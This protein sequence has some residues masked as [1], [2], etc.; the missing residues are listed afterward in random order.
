MSS[1]SKSDL[2]AGA[3]AA[4]LLAGLRGPA[5]HRAFAEGVKGGHDD[6]AHAGAVGDQQR[7]RGNA[8]HNAQHGEEAAQLVA[9]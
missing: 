9:L 1:F 8:P 4:R 7:H 5:N 6:E 3:L 2:L